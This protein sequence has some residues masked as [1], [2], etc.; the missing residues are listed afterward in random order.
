VKLYTLDSKFIKNVNSWEV[1]NKFSGYISYG[2]NQ[3]DYFLDGRRHRVG[4]PAYIC[5]NG[6]EFY[7]IGG[8]SVTKQQHDLLYSIMKLKGL[9]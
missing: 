7:Y 2:I 6:I 8:E 1:P 4:G 9:L 3:K 5:N